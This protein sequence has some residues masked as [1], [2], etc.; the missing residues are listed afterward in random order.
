MKKKF[1]FKNTGINAGAA[2]IGGG[3]TVL[4]DKFLENMD[5][6][7]RSGIGVVAGALI[8]AMSP[9]PKPNKP[10]A[11]SSFGDGMAGAAGKELIKAFVPGIAGIGQ[12]D[13]DIYED[14][15]LGTGFNDFDQGGIGAGFIDDDQAGIG[16]AYASD[17]YDE[18]MG[19]FDS[20]TS[21]VTAM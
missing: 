15:L 16:N 12:L 13:G 21:E 17:T 8:C 18:V 11:G 14:N 3:T 6:R 7:I 19:P 10:H 2:V 1:N 9:A 20:D 4:L 5:P